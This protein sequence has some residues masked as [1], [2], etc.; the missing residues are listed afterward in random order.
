M[1]STKNP[2]H[3]LSSWH[4]F[5][6]AVLLGGW[7]DTEVLHL[8]RIYRSLGPDFDDIFRSDQKIGH[9][10]VLFGTRKGHLKVE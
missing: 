1:V 9:R 2:A 8:K 6:Q 7:E 5:I 4:D 10:A 3:L